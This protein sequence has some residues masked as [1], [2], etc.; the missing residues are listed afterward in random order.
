M[1]CCF[2]LL[3]LFTGCASPNKANETES[4]Q[5]ITR[6]S[7]NQSVNKSRVN[8]V[9]KQINTFKEITSVCVIDTDEKMV[10]AFDVKQR[11]RFQLKSLREDVQNKI[12]HMYPQMDIIVSTDQKIIQEVKKLDKERKELSK[13]KLKKQ[14]E[15]I[16][17]KEK[18]E[19]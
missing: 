12:E 18:D 15:R 16:I 5:N 9:K 4:E 1:L 14:L 19:T 7:T 13:N 17:K 11:H 6:L 8:N 3:I 2:T 10:V